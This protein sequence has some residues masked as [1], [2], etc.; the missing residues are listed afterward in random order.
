MAVY[1]I[2]TWLRGMVDYD[3]PEATIMA[4]LFNNEVADGLPMSKI[5]EKQR[6]LCLADLL[7][8]LASSSTS[9]SGEYISDNGWSHQKSAKQ[10]VD[11]AGLVNRAKELYAKWN[12]DK[13][14]TAV[15]A[16][17]TVKP[18]Y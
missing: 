8:W 10:V 18:I 2:E 9:S 16:K 11:R 15:G 7:M 4:I 1:T 12:S 5:S 6:D 13:A 3:V 14:T 17:I